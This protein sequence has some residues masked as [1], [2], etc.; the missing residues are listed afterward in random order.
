M[1]RFAMPG[2]YVPALGSASS[3]LGGVHLRLRRQRGETIFHS[4]RL[5]DGDLL[6]GHLPGT[7]PGL[8]WWRD[9]MV[10]ITNDAW[11][12]GRAALAALGMRHP[13]VGIA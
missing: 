4:Q 13:A 2:E 7:V 1:I 9:F 5:W 8:V 12:A 11:F 3:E 6:R 10:N